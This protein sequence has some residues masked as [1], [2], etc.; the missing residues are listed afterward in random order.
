MEQTW[1]G[2]DARWLQWAMAGIWLVCA[3]VFEWLWRRT[4]AAMSGTEVAQ[5]LEVVLVVLF[6]GL[7]IGAIIVILR[8]RPVTVTVTDDGVTIKQ[9]GASR[10]I[11]Y[12]D[13]AAVTELPQTV[14][15]SNGIQIYPS[16][17]F[18]LRIGSVDNS[19]RPGRK[20]AIP[21][22]A[23]SEAQMKELAPAL[24]QACE[25]AGTHYYV[26]R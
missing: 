5:I 26:A 13:M 8:L 18:L 11:A 16:K 20:W 2:R 6:V 14:S 25:V 23:F 17:E 12:A 22:L 1:T 10:T 24:R 21:G 4:A 3:V 19:E 9:G 15:S 7:T